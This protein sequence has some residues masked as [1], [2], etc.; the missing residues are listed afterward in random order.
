MRSVE[1]GTRDRSAN[2][3]LAVRM[4]A[5]R[6]GG[7]CF[8]IGC[9]SSATLQVTARTETL[10]AA[11]ARRRVDRDGRGDAL[12]QARRRRAAHVWVV[13]AAA[14]EQGRAVVLL[15]FFCRRSWSLSRAFSLVVA[16][17]GTGPRQ[18]ASRRATRARC[19]W[20]ACVA[21]GSRR[22]SR[23]GTSRVWCSSPLFSRSVAPRA[24]L[25][26]STRT[27]AGARASRAGARRT[28][29][30][31]RR[32]RRVGSPNAERPRSSRS[33]FRTPVGR[34][35]VALL[36]RCVVS[37]APL[38]R[39]A[40]RRGRAHH[41]RARGAR[42]ARR[43]A[44]GAWGVRAPRALG[45]RGSCSRSKRPSWASPCSAR[46]PAPFAPL[47]E[48]AG[49]RGARAT[50]GRA[51]HAA[52]GVAHAACGGATGSPLSFVAVRGPRVF[53]V[54]L[55]SPL[56][57]PRC[58]LAPRRGGALARAGTRRTRDLRVE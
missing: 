31:T 33:V 9:L 25:P 42:S 41:A 49:G 1:R 4:Q 16:S 48:T 37:R 14:V 28:R 22:R 3:L 38:P 29:R 23:A 17:C 13:L 6:E 34:L 19:A 52:R 11:F 18:R 12:A 45:A 5:W 21:G 57:A 27:P 53:S 43:D 56:C 50:S 35:V 2:C 24:A 26:R 47:P 44:R 58:S 36:S 55:S 39:S 54:F 15:F 46:A 20:R 32:A 40:A 30:A 7:C 51:T 10:L 8:R